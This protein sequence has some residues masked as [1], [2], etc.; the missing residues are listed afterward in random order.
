[1]PKAFS[2]GQDTSVKAYGSYAGRLCEGF[3]R[4]GIVAMA[5]FR[6][7]FT[8]TTLKLFRVQSTSIVAFAK[9]CTSRLLN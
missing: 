9:T 4:S 7:V 6:Y 3:G 1:M 2:G 5:A 8:R